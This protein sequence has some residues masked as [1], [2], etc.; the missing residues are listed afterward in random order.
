M[1]RL[2]N[3]VPTLHVHA[4]ENATDRRWK[5]Q[6]ASARRLWWRQREGRTFDAEDQTVYSPLINMEAERAS[7]FG[8]HVNL[9]WSMSSIN[10]G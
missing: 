6:R 2:E 5:V 3:V 4:P 1:F 8:F 10:F 9:Q 7:G